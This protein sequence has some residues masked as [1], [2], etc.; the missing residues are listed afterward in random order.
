[1]SNANYGAVPTE[2]PE[3]GQ[4]SNEVTQDEPTTFYQR[5]KTHFEHPPHRH[6]AVIIYFVILMIG[7]TGVVTY[8]LAD[9]AARDQERGNFLGLGMEYDA[10]KH[11]EE[12][13]VSDRHW[14]LALLLS[15]FL[16]PL[17]VD[18]FYLGYVFLGILKLIT[19]GLGGIWWIID[20]V[21]IA[22]NVLSDGEGCVL[23]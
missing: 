16:G 8:A 19:G 3:Q 12:I 1:M 4:G 11:Y 18:R 2:D 17:G 21:L 10:N 14:F 5:V 23:H 22:L 13:C 9:K 15:I 20:V 6:R 7:L